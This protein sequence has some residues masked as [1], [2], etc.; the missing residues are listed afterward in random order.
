MD[1]TSADAK[2]ATRALGETPKRWLPADHLDAVR[3]FGIVGVLIALFVFLSFASDVF[4]TETNLKNVVDQ[5]VAVGLLAV[6]GSLVIIAGGFDLS[7]GAIFAVCAIVGSKL[8]DSGGVAEG[9]AAGLALGAFLGLCNGII[10][11]VG[12]INHFVGTLATSIVF[13]GLA[14]KISGGG[15]IIVENPSFSELANAEII[16]LKSS[17]VIFIAFAVICAFILNRTVLGRHIFATGGN[18][19]AA[20]LSGVRTA[21]TIAF[22]Y[23]LSG[24]AAGL[25]GLIV[26][27]RTLS[28]NAQ[29]GNG[30]IYN[31]I[32]AILVGGNS[33]MGGE[34]AIWRTICGV[35]ILALIANGFNLLGIDP[36]FQQIVTGLIIL[37]AVGLDAWTRRARR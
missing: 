4:L 13:L 20:R 19:E 1:S 36:L 33:V 37:G 6:A 31:A 10:C 23:I 24:T 28:T 32:A 8:V 29:T 25:A 14:A 35:L 22:T 26:A 12:R 16:G 5:S 21:R 7:A 27:A 17:T 2:E 15:L 34:G 18:L 3:D 11:T 9:I 30:I